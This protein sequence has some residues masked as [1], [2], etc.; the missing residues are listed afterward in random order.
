MWY[1]RWD[2]YG[3]GYFIDIVQEVNQR[4]EQ[5]SD[6]AQVSRLLQGD[7]GESE[8]ICQW[9]EEDRLIITL[10]NSIT[11]KDLSKYN[12]SKSL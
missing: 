4:S 5:S 8:G 1:T 9:I 10:V 7:T 11:L 12:K 6:V 3:N 2:L